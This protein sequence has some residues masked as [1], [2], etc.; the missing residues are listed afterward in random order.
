MVRH[1]RQ[2]RDTIIEAIQIYEA[3]GRWCVSN[4]TQHNFLPPTFAAWYPEIYWDFQQPAF[5]Q[6]RLHFAP[7][8]SLEG[9]TPSG[10]PVLFSMLL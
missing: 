9:S 5:D 6:K 1:E 8:Y 10:G 4:G 7:V 2:Q 3:R